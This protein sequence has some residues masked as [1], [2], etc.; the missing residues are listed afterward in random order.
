MRLLDRFAVHTARY[1]FARSLPIMDESPLTSS[2]FLLASLACAP[3]TPMA[4]LNLGNCLS[5]IGD[6]RAALGAFERAMALNPSD[7]QARINAGIAY[8]TLGEWTKGWALYEARFALLEFHARNALRGGDRAKTWDGSNLHGKTLLVFHEQGVGDTIMCLRYGQSL[9]TEHGAGRVIYRIPASLLRLVR[10]NVV[11]EEIVSNSERLPE[12]DAL[13][14]FMS[15]PGRCK[16]ASGRPYLRL[17]P[18]DDKPAPRTNLRVGV[19]WAGSPH[20]TGDKRRSIPAAEFSRLLNIPNV[21]FVSLQV[22]P[23]ADDLPTLDRPEVNDYYDTARI[24]Q[25][26]DLVITVD[27][28]LAHLAGALGVPTWIMLPF[29]PD[30]RWMLN[31]D[32]TVWY[33]S[34]RLFR[35]TKP[36]DWESVIDRVQRGLEVLTATRSAV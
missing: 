15:L 31:T 10:A 21:S 17:Y 7:P 32:R 5:A 36:G 22:G 26:L 16:Q 19:A 9:L 14:P 2:R 4:W 35:Q 8:I 25:G 24:L 1:F 13:V 3:G 18:G 30:F 20:H 28:S 23:R 6:V 12:Y 27:T 29:A 33:D 34:A 11:R